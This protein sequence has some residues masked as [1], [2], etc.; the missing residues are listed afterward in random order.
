MVAIVPFALAGVPIP[1]TPPPDYKPE[2]LAEAQPSEVSPG[3]LRSTNRALKGRH[4]RKIEHFPRRMP[5]F[6]GSGSQ[7][8]LHGAHAAGLRLCRPFGPNLV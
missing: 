4:V 3:L 5:P 2:G 7:L 6:Q 8:D 1:S